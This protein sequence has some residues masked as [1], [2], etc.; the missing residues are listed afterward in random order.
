MLVPLLSLGWV[1]VVVDTGAA[2]VQVS[3]ARSSRCGCCCENARLKGFE[4]WL[5]SPP[6]RN[7]HVRGVLAALLGG[8]RSSIASVP[9]PRPLLC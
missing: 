6:G 8:G 4:S 9:N 5:L 2:P 7:V 3:K 1:V